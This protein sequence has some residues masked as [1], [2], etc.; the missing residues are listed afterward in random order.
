V[1]ATLNRLVAALC[2]EAGAGQQQV[3]DAVIVGNAAMHHLF[4]GLPVEQLGRA[5]YV[6]VISDP[7][8]V[9]ARDLGLELVRGAYVHLPA[10]IAGFVGADHV[11]MALGTGVWET[12]RTVVPV[13]IGT[14]TEVTLTKGG[15]IWCCSCASGPAFEGAHIRDGMRAA[16]G[17]IERVRIANRGQPLLKIIGDLP[18]VGICGSGIMDA[19]SEMLRTGIVSRK[20]ATIEG[21]PGVGRDATTTCCTL[22]WRRQP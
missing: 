9:P 5:P 2:A 4:A 8:D 15:R 21:A 13:D 6:P 19:V 16:P 17:A 14:N 22:F 12:A 1:V 18:S 3:T 11:A 20:G 7:L 10:N